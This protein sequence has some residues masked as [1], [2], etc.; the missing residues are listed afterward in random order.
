M[1]IN[2]SPVQVG[3]LAI[4]ALFLF[5]A[6]SLYSA[7]SYIKAPELIP[8]PSGRVPLAAVV[9]F[10][11]KEEL[12]AHVKMTDG[13]NRWDA[14][15]GGEAAND[16]KYVIPLL[17]MRPDREHTITLTLSANGKTRDTLTFKHRTPGI[18]L[19]PLEWPEIDVQV[20]EIDRMEPGVLFLSV[21]RRTPGRGHWLTKKQLQFATQW[22]RIIALDPQGEVIWWYESESRTAGIDRL[23][24]GNIM[25]HRANFSTLE[26]DML[27]YVVREYYAEKR[28]QGPSKNPDAIALKDIQTLHHQPHQMPNGDFLAFAANAY[29]VKDYLTSDIDPHAPR[30]DALVMADTVV[31]FNAAGEQVWTW[32]TMDYLDPFRIGKDTFWSYWW[33]RGFPNARD[34][35]HGNGLSYDASDDSVLISLRNQSAV[36]KV[37][38]QTNEIKW[39]LGNHQ[40]WP[41]GLQDKLLTPIGKLRWPAYQHNPRMT[42]QGTVIM[43]DNRAH[44]GAMAYEE[45]LPPDQGWSR[46]VEFEIDEENKTV[47]QIW[48]SAEGQEGDYCYSFAMSEAWRLPIT[49]NRLVIH[50]FCVEKVKGLTA[51][52]MDSTKR[53]PVD[54]PWGGRILEYDG[55]DVVFRTEI[56]DPYGII[57]WTTYGGFKS[58]GI[59]P[60]AGG[61]H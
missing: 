46:A 44:G 49:D 13:T 32:N 60:S 18:S 53:A 12:D 29:E 61:T 25:M 20:A 59:Y 35:T 38:R 54:I 7:V 40:G 16:G 48:S 17:G 43:F 58:S 14:H 11:V 26:I 41:E 57:H 22:G 33:T 56:K 28:P 37:D 55:E 31:Q 9:E 6:S 23:N 27:G 1:K 19:N 36:L 30:E 2:Q 3:E 51:D 21:R 47:K 8:N 39:I 50:A 10:T 34:W 52:I 24:N 15:M 5:F 45:S 4:H 42:P